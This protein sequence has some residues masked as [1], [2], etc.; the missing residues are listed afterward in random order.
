[1]NANKKLQMY[2]FNQLLCLPIQKL[3]SHFPIP[4]PPPFLEIYPSYTLPN[5]SHFNFLLVCKILDKMCAILAKIRFNK[6]VTVMVAKSSKKVQIIELTMSEDIIV[7]KKM[8]GRWEWS[9]VYVGGEREGGG[10]HKNLS[11][12]LG[13]LSINS[14][15]MRG[16]VD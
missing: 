9:V 5:S 15:E 2:N 6:S 3:V 14:M 7:R 4:F 10:V 16:K 13:R 12:K 8:W 11:S 1:M